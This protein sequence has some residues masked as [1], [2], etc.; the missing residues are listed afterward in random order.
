MEVHE[1]YILDHVSYIL[2]DTV[3]NICGFG[4]QDFIFIF[5]LLL[6]LLSASPAILFTH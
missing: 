1:V 3:V 4:C 5:F 6:L 2:H